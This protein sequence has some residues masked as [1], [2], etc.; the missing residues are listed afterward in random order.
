MRPNPILV[1]ILCI[2]VVLST[3]FFATP[4]A[5]QTPGERTINFSARLRTATGTVVP[6]G[7]Y[8]ISFHIYNQSTGGAQLWS[9]R[10]HDTNGPAAGQDYRVEVKNGYLSTQLGSR[11]AFGNNINWNE[12]L[13]LTM[14][15]GGTQ[16]LADAEAIQWDGEMTPRIALSAVPYAMNA[17]LLNGR[18]S[19]QFVQLGQGAQTSSGNNPLIHLNTTGSGDFIRLQRNAE[20]VFTVTNAGDIVL[21]S[22]NNHSISIAQ[23][24]NDTDGRTLSISGGDG[25]EGD[26]N[27]GD[28]RIAGGTG[29]GDGAN[30]LVI[31]GATAY[32][33]V[34]DDSNCY[35]GGAVVAASC[36]VSQATIDS[37]SSVTLGFSN[38]EQ[39]ATIPDP[40]LLT[41]GR[42]L[43]VMAAS[44]SLPFTLAANDTDHVTVAPKSAHILLWNGSDWTIVGGAGWDAPEEAQR[45][46][47]APPSETEY[48]SLTIESS[49]PVEDS[50]AIIEGE[51]LPL[52]PGRS[53]ADAS[54]APPAATPNEDAL[55][56]L[57]R[58]ETAPSAG[59]GSDLFGSMY[60]DETLGKVQCF[61]ASGW[62]SCGDAPDTFV[63]ISPEYPNAVMNGSANGTF[64][65][66]I[67]S[68]TLGIN[69]GAEAEPAICGENETYN[70]YHWTSQEESD[71]ARSIYLTYQ[72]PS[73][74]KAFMAD[75]TS[76]MG[77]TDND[78]A[79][80]A[81]QIFKNNGDGLTP[82]GTT[83]TIATG[84]NTA[85]QKGS[86]RAEQDPANCGFQAGD[87][88]LFKIDL[89]AR[90]DANAYLSTVN[91]TFSNN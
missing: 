9:E 10:Y 31:L 64:S 51:Q 90:D 39:T 69:S 59:E 50:P 24:G 1:R 78:N 43:H 36:T 28:V 15:I 83:T 26:T 16:Q 65:S 18:S 84:A 33:T 88:M 47:I 25:G 77:R 71:Q 20:D 74:F 42:I 40:T 66:D 14:N 68:G 23:S 8:N 17:G 63:S 32:D 44:D 80:A 60:Y 46:T 89:T 57:G 79:T 55:L 87:S 38:P 53:E 85:W 2:F 21:G 41:P 19:D 3:T 22:S 5:A 34:Q 81:Y 76:I 11:T 82:C 72:L 48:Q 35:S 56:Q 7:K 54:D 52:L 73:N 4:A 13:W 49:Q 29:Q 6:D 37:A 12:N 67:C 45:M 30:G 58:S 86:A 75:T 27:G 70:F 62:G 61:E 91:F